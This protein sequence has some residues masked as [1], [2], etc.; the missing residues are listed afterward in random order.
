MENETVTNRY[1]E[2]INFEAAV[3]LMDDD[4]REAINAELAPC[5][6]Q[7]FFEAYCKAHLEKY[8]EEFEP[9]KQNPQW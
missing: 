8:H 4:L 9:N 5:S 3:N 1:G 6:N 2:P 7:E